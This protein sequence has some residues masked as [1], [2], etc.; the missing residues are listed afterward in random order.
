MHWV[1]CVPVPATVRALQLV[2]LSMYRAGERCM[3]PAEITLCSI[4]YAIDPAAA[5]YDGR[6]G[7]SCC[8]NSNLTTVV[9]ASSYN[10]MISLLHGAHTHV[11]SCLASHS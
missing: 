5:L 1:I 7:P 2:V 6:P 9:V 4:N 8:Q 11:I 3:C 10:T